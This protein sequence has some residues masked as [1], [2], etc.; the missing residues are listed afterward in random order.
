MDV[1]TMPEYIELKR[2][3][4]EKTQELESVREDADSRVANMESQV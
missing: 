3:L 4:E 2:E 1:T